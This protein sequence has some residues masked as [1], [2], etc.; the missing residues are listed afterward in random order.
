MKYLRYL[1]GMYGLYWI[2]FMGGDIIWSAL[3]IGLAFGFI[4]FMKG[5]RL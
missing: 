3:W 2:G 4:D 1:I 5:E